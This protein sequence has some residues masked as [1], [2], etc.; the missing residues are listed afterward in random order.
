MART[1]Q[2]LK[3][4]VEKLIE[5]QGKDAPVA[6]F[7]FTQEDV[8]ELDSEGDPIYLPLDDV[9]KVLQK[10]G[11]GDYIFEQVFEC[12]DDEIRRLKIVKKFS[13]SQGESQ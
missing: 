2:Q 8:F 10:I 1:L 4:S 11:Y 5:S 7:I 3:E 6:A 9:D 12:I 13:T